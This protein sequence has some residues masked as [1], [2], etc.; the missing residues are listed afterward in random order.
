MT[1]TDLIAAEAKLYPGP[2]CQFGAF[3]RS[4]SPEDAQAIA[5]FLANPAIEGSLIARVIPKWQGVKFSATSIRTHRR[6]DCKC[7]R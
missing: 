4:L 1:L 3:L 7:P 5:A 2:K 6:G